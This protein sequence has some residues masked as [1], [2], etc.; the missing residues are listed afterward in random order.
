MAAAC[1]RTYDFRI[2][3]KMQHQCTEHPCS[4]EAAAV[5]FS[6]CPGARKETALN[7]NPASANNIHAASRRRGTAK[8]Q[9]ALISA[10][11][12][13]FLVNMFWLSPA[14]SKLLKSRQGAE[15]M[16]SLGD[17][18]PH[19]TEHRSQR[20]NLRDLTVRANTLAASEEAKKEKEYAEQYMDPLYNR[21]SVAERLVDVK[22]KGLECVVSRLITAWNSATSRVR[23]AFIHNYMPSTYDSLPSEEPMMFYLRT[24]AA[25]AKAWPE[26]VAP[27]LIQDFLKEVRF[28]DS[29][30]KAATDRIEF[31]CKLEQVC[32]E[33]QVGSLLLGI[34]SPPLPTLQTLQKDQD[35]I[36]FD[37]F[38]EMLPWPRSVVSIESN[39]NERIPKS[40]ARRLAG[41]ALAE[42]L[43]SS[44]DLNVRN[45]IASCAYSTRSGVT[46]AHIDHS[47][48]SASV[49]DEPLNRAA[50]R[51]HIFGSNVVEGWAQKWNLKSGIIQLNLLE[52][53]AKL[54][55]LE[56]IQEKKNP[57]V[58]GIIQLTCALL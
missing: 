12:A 25:V 46:V 2:D 48:F 42:V 5:T 28:V 16:F 11:L 19:G 15:M 41:V 17:P 39:G 40:L 43:E 6:S 27:Q 3:V 33:F 14:S 8:R 26:Q 57:C 50:A 4:R 53:D 55:Y 36:S 47:I 20:T 30:L 21:V 37:E 45:I 35:E 34:A 10:L 29:V 51:L 56:R 58:D 44:S 1:P 23:D 7:W 49:L 54:R 22:L 38:F 18:A 31:L 32:S 13:A 24:A 52:E 9:A